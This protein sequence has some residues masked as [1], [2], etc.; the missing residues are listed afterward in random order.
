MGAEVHNVVRSVLASGL[1]ALLAGCATQGIKV[2]CDGKL[3]PIN[4]PAPK[5]AAKVA[6]N[7][8]AQAPLAHPSREATP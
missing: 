3:T 2:S 1:L 7:V 5:V 8:A 4:T 6:A